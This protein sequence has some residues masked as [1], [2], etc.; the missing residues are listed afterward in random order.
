MAEDFLELALGDPISIEQDPFRRK[1]S[2]SVF[3]LLSVVNKFVD[4]NLRDGDFIETL[5]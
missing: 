4:H 5:R 2:F 1:I 3:D